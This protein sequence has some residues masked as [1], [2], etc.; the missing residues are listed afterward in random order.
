MKHFRKIQFA[1]LLIL[2]FS[3]NGCAHKDATETIIDKHVTH[4]NETL[5]YAQT[6]FEQTQEV[7]YLENELKSCTLTLSAVRESHRANLETCESRTDYWRLA[8][9]GLGGLLVLLLVGFFK[10]KFWL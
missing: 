7:V 2:A 1:I 8:C 6:N 9:L 10:K 4:F 3:L 5:Q